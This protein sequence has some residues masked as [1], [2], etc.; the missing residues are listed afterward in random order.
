MELLA[1]ILVLSFL[2][3]AKHTEHVNINEW[4]TLINTKR[5]R[6]FILAIIILFCL[7][8]IG[9]ILI[10]LFARL[11]EDLTKNLLIS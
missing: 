9:Q 5:N 10:V 2:K 11:T 1:I 6:I 3:Y 4:L 8:P 7:T